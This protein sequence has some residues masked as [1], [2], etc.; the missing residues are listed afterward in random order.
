VKKI[1]TQAVIAVFLL[2]ACA[3]NQQVGATEPPANTVWATPDA[4][5]ST[6]TTGF[7]TVRSL[8]GMQA[9]LLRSQPDPKSA[10]AGQVTPGEKG[11]VLGSNADGT[12]VLLK[13]S[14]KSG[15]APVAALELVIAQ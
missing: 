13:F 10:L 4:S 1:L 15:W 3:A 9:L 5:M 11:Q 6:P 8:Q 7:A 14:E 2:G 12:W